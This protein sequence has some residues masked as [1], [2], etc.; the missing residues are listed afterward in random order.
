MHAQAHV[1]GLISSPSQPLPS[2]GQS[3]TGVGRDLRSQLDVKPRQLLVINVENRDILTSYFEVCTLCVYGVLHVGLS[4]LEHTSCRCT[5]MYVQL[6]YVSL[7]NLYVSCCS[8]F[9][10]CTLY[11]Y[12][13]LQN[14]SSHLEA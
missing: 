11:V 9:Y 14:I 13:F 5:C 10:T 8:V 6:Y 1:L 3:K 12:V 2:A 7:G 4:V